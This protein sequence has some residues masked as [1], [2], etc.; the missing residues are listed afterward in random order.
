MRTT[1]KLNGQTKVCTLKIGAER[2]RFRRHDFENQGISVERFDGGRT[3]RK[4]FGHLI[5]ISAGG[6]RIRTPEASVKPDSHIRVRLELPPYAGIT[7]FVD[8]S[9]P[10]LAGKREWVGWMTVRRVQPQPD[11]NYDVAG[12]L[13]DMEELDRGMLGLYLSTQPLAA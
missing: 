8:T 1:E 12:P 3:G 4:I 11:G 6:V 10:Q 9:G 7:P 2:R 5:D 13:V